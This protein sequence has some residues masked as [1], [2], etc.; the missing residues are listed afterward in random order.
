MK[1][2]RKEQIK[3]ENRSKRTKIT[4]ASHLLVGKI[5]G[6]PEEVYNLLPINEY[7]KYVL[8]FTCCDLFNF[9]NKSKLD[10]ATSAYPCVFFNKEK[11]ILLRYGFTLCGYA[12]NQNY[13]SLVK[14]C[15]DRK[16]KWDS[17]FQSGLFYHGDNNFFKKCILEFEYPLRDNTALNLITTGNFEG[18]ILAS[19]NIKPNIIWL[20]Y[21]GKCGN[22]EIFEWVY[23]QV[24]KSTIKNNDK[25]FWM[26]LVK[27]G[28]LEIVKFLLNKEGESIISV[29]I[30]HWIFQCLE[31]GHFNILS[32]LHTKFRDVFDS[33]FRTELQSCL[34]MCAISG[35]I[36]IME[37]IR[38]T[39]NLNIS[40]F[41]FETTNSAANKNKLDMLKWLININGNSYDIKNIL[42][43]SVK[44]EN[45]DMVK[46]IMETT[47]NRTA[48][49]LSFT[50]E[51]YEI[52]I[53]KNLE[54]FIIYFANECKF[55]MTFNIYT[56][57]K[58]QGKKQIAT[59]LSKNGC[60]VWHN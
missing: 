21:S 25:Y 24:N 42:T 53:S 47:K 4:L 37:W 31:S 26:D 15:L 48:L 29:L 20:A 23:S 19:K 28:N 11:R 17:K 30:K 18:L 57:A 8:Q 60:P 32:Y 36:P 34:S 43:E 54:Q 1:R 5:L 12:F 50:E 40:Q 14:W 10:F 9:V 45:L 39:L 3:E 22:F 44:N 35:S 52:A 58:T 41:P 6:I 51:L 33:I 49:I 56:K 59:W 46:F 16:L 2:K 55:P 7:D 27:G 13:Q 38:D